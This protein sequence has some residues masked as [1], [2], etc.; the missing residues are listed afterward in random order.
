MGEVGCEMLV[1]GK[2]EVFRLIVLA[3]GVTAYTYSLRSHD[4]LSTTTG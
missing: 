3:T 2:A 4:F 1:V